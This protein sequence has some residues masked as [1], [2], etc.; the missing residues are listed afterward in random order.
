MLVVGSV[1][2]SL[3]KVSC[4]VHAK[5]WLFMLYNKRNLMTRSSEGVQA[6]VKHF[7]YVDAK[8]VVSRDIK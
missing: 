2:A 8:N 7:L 5:M 6:D 3:S 1:P 4:Y